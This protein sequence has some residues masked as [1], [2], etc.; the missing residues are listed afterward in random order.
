M[1]NCVLWN[2]KSLKLKLIITSSFWKILKFAAKKLMWWFTFGTLWSTLKK[3]CCSKLLL[4]VNER[5]TLCGREPGKK[6]FCKFISRSSSL[7]TRCDIGEFLTPL[8]LHI[9]VDEG[10]VFMTNKIN[11]FKMC[12]F[13]HIQWVYLY[14]YIRH[15]KRF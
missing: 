5:S 2:N 1:Y 8:A 10:S 14:P 4:W 3:K 13:Q 11:Y 12:P 15:V 7:I 6:K 9:Y